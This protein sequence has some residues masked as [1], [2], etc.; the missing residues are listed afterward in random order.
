MH[1]TLL[2]RPD[3]NRRGGGGVRTACQ[4]TPLCNQGGLSLS[5]AEPAFRAPC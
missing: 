3:M 5:L 2:V 1:H 4:R